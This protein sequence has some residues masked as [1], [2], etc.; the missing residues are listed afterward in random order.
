MVWLLCLIEFVFLMATSL[1][2]LR[3]P[4]NAPFVALLWLQQ[5]VHCGELMGSDHRLDHASIIISCDF[6]PPFTV[7]GPFL[8]F[9]GLL[10]SAFSALLAP[11]SCGGENVADLSFKQVS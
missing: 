6:F 2:M 4:V 7:V 10:V 1:L 9:S 3:C 11:V 8:D 5:A